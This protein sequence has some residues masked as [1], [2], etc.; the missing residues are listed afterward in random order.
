ML[1]EARERFPGLTYESSTRHVGFGLVVEEA[2]VRDVAGEA[3]AALAAEVDEA[4]RV[5]EDEV[6]AQTHPMW[7]EPV[8]GRSTELVLWNEF[9]RL[10]LPLPPVPLNMPVRVTVRHDDLQVHEVVLSFPA[11]LLKRAL[12]QYVDPLEMSLSE[13]QSAFI[14]PA[15]AGLTTVPLDGPPLTLADAPSVA[16]PLSVGAP[17]SAAP[18]R[19]R[20]R[21]LVLLVLLVLA[22]LAGAGWW[23]VQGRQPAAG[24]GLATG[25][26]FPR[27]ASAS[28]PSQSTTQQVALVLGAHGD[29][30]PVHLRAGPH[31]HGDAEVG[32]G[33][34][35]QQLDAVARGEGRSRHR[36]EAGTHGRA[37]REDL[38]RRLHRRHRL[39]GVRA[40]AVAAPGRRRV[41]LPAVPAPRRTGL[42]RVRRARRGEPDREQRHRSR[43]AAE[44]PG[45]DH[46]APALT[47]YRGPHA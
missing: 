25:S 20:R 6:R 30:D 43:P 3:E 11:A 40:G 21:R 1:R 5:A 39:G 2:R 15:G 22:I 7:D 42:H 13:V 14:A 23:A 12:G 17:T 32:P 37:D 36:R 26:G 47:A 45:H 27:V 29:P 34:R 16:Q 44:P 19:R 24:R 33:V 38:R 4:A 10:D 35:V 41:H 18:R 46:V 9:G 31:T 28:K 8:R